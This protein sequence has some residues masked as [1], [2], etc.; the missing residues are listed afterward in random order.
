MAYR[1]MR[2][3]L[4]ETRGDVHGPHGLR[5]ATFVETTVA[6]ERASSLALAGET[7]A[8]RLRY[9]EREEKNIMLPLWNPDHAELFCQTVLA[10]TAALTVVFTSLA[11]WLRC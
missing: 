6:V 10:L 2:R 8:G 4:D 1:E 11:T 3:T 9:E 7:Q 5:V